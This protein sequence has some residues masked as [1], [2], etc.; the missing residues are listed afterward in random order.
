MQSLLHL[1]QLRTDI[2]R[3]P[4]F[5]LSSCSTLEEAIRSADIKVQFTC[6]EVV[7]RFL[8]VGHLL[9]DSFV[10]ECEWLS[11]ETLLNSIFI[12]EKKLAYL[13]KGDAHVSI[14]SLHLDRVLSNPKN[15][16]G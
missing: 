5:C 2:D 8:T 11:R 13:V 16:V 7:G 3:N 6:D 14:S 4:Q 10:P 12:L 15:L 1:L 9:Q